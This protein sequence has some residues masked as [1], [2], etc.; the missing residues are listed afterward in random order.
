MSTPHKGFPLTLLVRFS[1]YS[2]LMNDDTMYVYCPHIIVLAQS[3]LLNTQYI[4][5]DFKIVPVPTRLNKTYES[6]FNCQFLSK[7]YPDLLK[8]P[9]LTKYRSRF[10][11]ILN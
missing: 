5:Q 10:Y 8:M 9:F 6:W 2:Q 1:S 7:N 4:S 3:R 11:F